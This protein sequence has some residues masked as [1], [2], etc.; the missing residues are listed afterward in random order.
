[1]VG[2]DELVRLGDVTVA[3]IAERSVRCHTSHAMAIL[4]AKH[5]LAVLIRSR[6]MTIACEVAGAPI[7]LLDLDQ[8]F[9]GLRAEFESL[10][11]RD[12]A[13]DTSEGG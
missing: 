8:R 7:A 1:M 12:S 4:A 5:P 13:V 3:A 6:G 10:A 2:L 11:D 9:P